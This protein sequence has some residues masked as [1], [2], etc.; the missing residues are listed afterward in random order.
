LAE[1]ASTQARLLFFLNSHCGSC[2]RIAD[3]VDGWAYQLDPAVGILVVYVDESAAAGQVR[4]SREVATWEP[5]LN[6]QRVLGLQGTPAAVLL[7]ADGLLAGGPVA[8]EDDILELVEAVSDEIAAPP[9]E[10]PLV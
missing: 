4:H 5:E 1:L 9:R 2:L 10:Q 6:V 7:G 8:G 3:K